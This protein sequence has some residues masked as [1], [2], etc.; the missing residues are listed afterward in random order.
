MVHGVKVADYPFD[1]WEKQAKR[2]TKENEKLHPGLHIQ[3]LRWLTR[4]DGKDFSTLI[5]EANSAEYANCIICEGVVLGYDLKIVERYDTKCR[6]T[7]CF[8]CQK[9][10]HISTICLNTEKCGYCGD[11]HS[12][13]SCTA[14]AQASR[15]RCAGCNGGNHTAWSK[16][17]P[18]RMKELGRAKAAKLALPRLFSVATSVAQYITQ[19]LGGH[20]AEHEYQPGASQDMNMRQ[21]GASQSE[22]GVL[23]APKKRK[24]NSIGRPKGSINKAKTLGGPAA[25]NSSILDF[26]FSPSQAPQASDT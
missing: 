10:G 23:E 24:L 13:E 3:G 19:S 17:C 22:G 18:A 25:S 6:I 16:D 8:K 14:K 5:V 26:N 15:K 11:R 4:P 20:Q 21:T 7:Q 1:A 12:S 9:Y 2:L